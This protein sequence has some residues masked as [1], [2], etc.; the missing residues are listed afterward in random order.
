MGTRIDVIIE[1]RP[2]IVVGAEYESDRPGSYISCAGYSHDSSPVFREQVERV[3]LF[4]LRE[5]EDR[6]ARGTV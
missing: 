5:L 3:I 4:L 1:D 2:D 6:A